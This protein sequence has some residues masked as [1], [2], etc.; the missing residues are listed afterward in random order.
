MAART[1]LEAKPFF[2]IIPQ[3]SQMALRQ[4]KSLTSTS[5]DLSDEPNAVEMIFKPIACEERLMID[6]CD[7]LKMCE[8]EV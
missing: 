5:L 7:W 3:F 4:L 8:M 1:R 6:A 2:L